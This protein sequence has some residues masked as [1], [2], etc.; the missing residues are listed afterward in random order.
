MRLD[1]PCP[2]C[3]KPIADTALVCDRCVR[4]LGARL[5]WAAA[6]LDTGELDATIGRQTATAGG[7]SLAKVAEQLPHAGPWCYGGGHDCGHPSC[8]TIWRSWARHRDEPRLAHEDPGPLN[9]DAAEVGYVIGH[10]ARA[11]AE[12]VRTERGATIPTRPARPRPPVLNVVHD[13]PASPR[14]WCEYGDLPA[15]TCACG[16][17]LA[18]HPRR[19]TA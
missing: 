11:W 3:G 17:P 12:Y 18:T 2:L 1:N 6:M 9:L 19:T 16:N 5:R 15:D 4:I 8:R 13:A 10:T 14:E 7:P